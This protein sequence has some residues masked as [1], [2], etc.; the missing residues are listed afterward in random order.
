LNALIVYRA[1]FFLRSRSIV[2][3]DFCSAYGNKSPTSQLY[4]VQH[5]EEKITLNSLVPM[6]LCYVI[7]KNDE[8]NQEAWKNIPVFMDHFKCAQI[9]GGAHYDTYV[10][11]LK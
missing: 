9:Q 4:G 11:C 8:N 2:F 10:V 7:S 1:F 5:A 6:P 3:V